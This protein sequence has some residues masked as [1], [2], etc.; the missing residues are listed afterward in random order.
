MSLPLSLKA[1]ALRLLAQRE[2]S[3]S[4]LRRKLWPHALAAMDTPPPVPASVATSVSGADADV[5]AAAAG[6]VDRLLDAL[7]AAGQLSD[8]RFV[9]SRIHARAPRFGNRRIETELARLGVTIDA[10]ASQTLRASELERARELWRRRFGQPAT[11]ARDRAR[12][13]RFLAGRGFP[14]E[15]IRRVVPATS[16]SAGAGDGAAL[17]VDD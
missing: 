16:G 3:R 5:R 13:M 2:H 17:E 6:A 4:E 1:R 10:A 12:Q 9:E 14:A 15:V 8:S 11:D 7:E